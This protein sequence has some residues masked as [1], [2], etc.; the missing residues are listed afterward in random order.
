MVI[1]QVG[2]LV[3]GLGRLDIPSELYMNLT[4]GYASQLEDVEGSQ[5][6]V[7]MHGGDMGYPNLEETRALWLSHGSSTLRG[8]EVAVT[9]LVLSQA[10]FQ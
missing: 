1:Y 4:Q 8:I 9:K 7:L 10:V 2:T 6:Q 5:C 3:Q